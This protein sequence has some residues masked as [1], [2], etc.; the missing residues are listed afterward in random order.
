MRRKTTLLL[1][2]L[3]AC[4]ML[5]ACTSKKKDETTSQAE[6]LD[7]GWQ[8]G[9][10]VTDILTDEQRTMFEKVTETLTG[11]AYEPAAV[12]ATQVVSGTNYAYL[13]QSTPSTEMEGNKTNWSI[14]VVY[15][16]LKGK[17]EI[18]SI[19]DIDLT[20]IAKLKEADKKAVGAY[21][22][23]QDIVEAETLPDEAWDAFNNATSEYTGLGL[24]PIALLGSQVVSGMNYSVLCYGM[25]ATEKPEVDLYVVEIYVN[26]DD[27]ASI[28]SVDVFDLNSYIE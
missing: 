1:S 26:P 7:G 18:T 4:A 25:T 15:K 20:K 16:D 28:T 17:L 19:K 8:T 13:A 10:F 14:V 3:L 27:E 21:Q 2:L 11:A 23:N 9:E 22:A 24:T 5:C 12:L 6:T